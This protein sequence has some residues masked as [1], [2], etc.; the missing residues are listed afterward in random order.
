[1]EIT[2]S[3]RSIAELASDFRPVVIVVSDVT[4]N[5]KIQVPT[6]LAAEVFSIRFSIYRSRSIRRV[7]DKTAYLSRD[8]GRILE[9]NLIES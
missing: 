3:A 9:Q 6:D 7:K 5:Y 1:M 8:Y 4:G 2:C